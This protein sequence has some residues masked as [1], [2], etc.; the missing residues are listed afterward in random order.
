[1]TAYQDI[2]DTD[3]RNIDLPMSSVAIYPKERDSEGLVVFSYQNQNL[4]STERDK[5]LSTGRSKET[6]LRV[7]YDEN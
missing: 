4:D 6:E 5:L 7:Q 2:Q 3:G 1:M